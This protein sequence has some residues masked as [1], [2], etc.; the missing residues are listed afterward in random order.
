MCGHRLALHRL[1]ALDG[2]STQQI[3]SFPLIALRKSS[4]PM[5]WIAIPG[6]RVKLSFP[7]FDL[8]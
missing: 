5:Y 7:F 1:S 8:E 6:F 3:P 4:L 2:T